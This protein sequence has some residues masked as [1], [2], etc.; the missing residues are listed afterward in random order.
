MTETL[1]DWQPADP[2]DLP[3][4]LGEDALTWAAE[5]TLSSVHVVGMLTSATGQQLPLDLLCV[6]AAFPAPVVSEQIRH[7][8][9]QAWHYDQVLLLHRSGS[10]ALGVPM[11]RI[12]ADLTC[13][14]LRRFAKAVGVASDRV[15]VTLRL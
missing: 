7:D 11:T 13:D 10:T 15:S 8:V 6:D 2:F 12:D 14:A 9:H 3:Q 5:R 4:W 1:H